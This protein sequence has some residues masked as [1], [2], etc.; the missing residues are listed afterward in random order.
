MESY[1]TKHARMKMQEW[2]GRAKKAE[3][4]IKDLERTLLQGS[5][6]L[7]LEPVVRMKEEILRQRSYLSK[8]QNWAQHWQEKL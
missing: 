6:T 3:D 1:K 5:M 4:S 2:L 7:S 8:A